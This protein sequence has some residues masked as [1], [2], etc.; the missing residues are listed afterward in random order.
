MSQEKNT[1]GFKKRVDSFFGISKL[2]SSFKV[3][4]LAG[5][6]TFFAMAYI[7]T[8]NPNN[9]LYE[10]GTSDSRW[11]SI[12][13]ATAIGSTIGTLLMSLLAKM[14]LA[15]APGL[16]LNST[17]GALIGGGLGAIAGGTMNLGTALLLVFTSGLIFFL[18]S[19]IP[20]GRN[21]KGDLVSLREKIFDGIP[22]AIRVSIPV[23]IGLFIAFIGFKN[24]NLIVSNPNTVVSLVD[25]TNGELFANGGPAAQAIVC[26]FGLFMIGVLSHYKIKG[27]VILGIISATILAIPL[28]VADF[29]VLAGQTKGITWK[30]WE[31]FQNF[32]S[33]NPDAG[34]VFLACFTE[35]FSAFKDAGASF[36]MSCIVTVISFCMIQMFDTMGTVVGCCKNAGLMDEDGK[37]YNYGK[38]M[39]SD[40]VA[41]VVGSCLGTSTITV[42]VESGVGV[43]AGGK[44]GFTAL[45]VALLFFLSIF[46]LPVFA[47]IPSAAASSALVYV[48]VL[49]MGNVKEVDFGNVKNAIPAFLA[50]I[51]MP[52]TLSITKGIGV[53]IVAYVFIDIIC[54]LID[55]IRYA[56]SKD[57]NKVKPKWDLSIVFLIVCAFF[58]LYFLMPTNF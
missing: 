47:F 41:T 6:A 43:A 5:I 31:N 10:S 29:S 18:L 46:I 56:G 38:I 22:K 3:E 34:G 21:K 35:G 40:S 25:F 55:L 45:I 7:L 13:I 32:F 15:Q 53:G 39:Y 37:P 58:L 4:I 57:E 12:F 17:V 51:M 19:V 30:F 14:P 23:G 2:G 20:C 48:G 9:I 36:Y 33:M 49:M 1:Q 42:F 27:A 8:V 11:A 54:Y 24:A 52:L 50:I 44:T 28:Q 26:L 16:G